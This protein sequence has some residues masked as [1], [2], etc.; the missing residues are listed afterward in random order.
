LDLD[1]VG[2]CHGFSLVRCLHDRPG[3]QDLPNCPVVSTRYPRQLCAAPIYE[4]EIYETEIYETEIYE[5]ESQQDQNGSSK[6][7]SLCR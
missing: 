1:G 2:V 7:R 5:T 6:T 3:Q 4:T